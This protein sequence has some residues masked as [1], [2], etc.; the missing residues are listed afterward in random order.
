[1]IIFIIAIVI[2]Y[3]HYGGTE[4]SENPVLIPDYTVS[5][6]FLCITKSSLKTKLDTK[7]FPLYPAIYS[8]CVGVNQ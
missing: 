8:I 2:I 5:Y 3:P 7:I 1:M 4:S 6:W